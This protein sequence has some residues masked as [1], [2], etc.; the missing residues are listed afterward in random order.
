VGNTLNSVGVSSKMVEKGVQELQ[1]GGLEKVVGMLEAHA[2]DLAGFV[3]A[4]PRG[5]KLVPLLR[6]L[7]E[8]LGAERERTLEELAGLAE[9]LEHIRS[10]VASQQ[11][12]ATRTKV[13]QVCRLSDLVEKA[14]EITQQASSED[15]RLSVQRDYAELPGFPT[16]RGK[17][18]GLLVNLVQNARQAIERQGAEQPELRLRV[19]PRACGGVTIEVCD[20]GEGIPP[21]NLETIFEHGFT[22]KSDGH[23]F[24]LHS[25][26]NSAVEL[27]GRLSTHS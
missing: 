22:T 2:D 14:L 10:L 1:L 9:G 4:D 3:S 21:A 11:E 18:L 27:G 19:A 26:A 13:I 25:A 20:N 17:L 12:F 8:R 15:S 23:G 7:A 5:Q 24:G 16:D 6:A